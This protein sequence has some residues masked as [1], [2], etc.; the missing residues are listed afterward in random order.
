MKFRIIWSDEDKEKDDDNKDND[1][2]DSKCYLDG[3]DSD[4]L[5]HIYITVH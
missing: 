4:G 2:N 5:L 1:D 3:D